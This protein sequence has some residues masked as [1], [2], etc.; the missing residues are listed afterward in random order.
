[1]VEEGSE[2]LPRCPRAA[3]GGAPGLD[4]PAL[5]EPDQPGVRAPGGAARPRA[6]AA[7]GAVALSREVLVMHHAQSGPRF[8]RDRHVRTQGVRSVLCVPVLHQGRVTGVLYLENNATTHAF[9]AARVEALHVIAG[10]AAICIANSE[11]YAHL[12][13]R[14]QERTRELA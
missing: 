10:Q 11:L 1:L 6:G 2:R 8:A 9:T 3:A 12:E 13:R 7:G 4:A 14:V 5:P